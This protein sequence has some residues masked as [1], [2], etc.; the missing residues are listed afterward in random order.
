VSGDADRC[1]ADG[2]SGAFIVVASAGE[3]NSLTLRSYQ[4]LNAVTTTQMVFH[5]GGDAGFERD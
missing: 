4:R 3:V 1:T 5:G 2:L